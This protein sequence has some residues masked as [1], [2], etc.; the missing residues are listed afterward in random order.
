MPTP[1]VANQ[2]ISVFFSYSHKDE[3]L[4]DELAK[5]L[6]SLKR[7][8]VI[9]TWHDR[10][11]TAGTEW[12]GQL[13][14]HLESAQVIL[15]LV[16][17]DF[18]ASDYCYDIEMKRA[19]ERSDLGEA[20]VIP[21]I[22]RAV[23][24]EDEPFAKLQ[25]LP[26]NIKPI[27][28]WADRDE[29][30][31]DV[32]K[33][34]RKAVNEIRNSLQV[35]VAQKPTS[36]LKSG[37]A[38]IPLQMPPKP[39]NL[40]PRPEH[41]EALKRRLIQE[42][43]TESGT[44]VVSAIYGLGGIGKSVL[45]TVVAHDPDVQ[46][47]FGDGILWIT[48]GQN[49]DIQK[50][51]GAWIQALKDFDYKPTTVEAASNHLR[52]LLYDKRMLLVVDDVWESDHLDPFRVGGKNCSVLVTTREAQIQDA[53]RYE[54]DEMTEAQSIKLLEG[55]MGRAIETEER[56]EV[57]TFAE[58]VGH[59]P[60]ALELSAVQVSEGLTWKEFQDEL[61]A[62]FDL[63]LFDSAEALH[64]SSEEKRRKHSLQACFNL[65]LRRLSTELLHQF[66]GL[67]I[68]PEDVVITPK[69]AST[70]WGIREV[71]AKKVLII[72]KNRAFLTAGPTL[73]DQTQTYRMHDL[74]HD[75]ARWLIAQ[76]QDAEL[77]GLG[78]TVPE[79]QQRFLE[80]Y[81]QQTQAGQWHTLADD[82]YIHA[83]L[84]WH[85]EQAGWGDQIHQ[86]L[87]EVTT[88]GRNGW[89]EACDRL[90]QT[91]IFVTDVGRAWRLAEEMYSE[92]KSRSIALQVRYALIVATLNSLASNIPA[93]LVAALVKKQKWTPAQGLAYAQQAQDSSQRSEIIQ[94]LVANLPPVSLFEKLEMVRGIQDES[95]RATAL[96]ELVP[97]LPGQ[98]LPEAI[99]VAREIQDE[100]DQASVLS[101]LAARELDQLLSKVI[102]VVRGI[103]SEYSQTLILSEL[104]YHLLEL[105][106]LEALEVARGI[107]NESG[108]A[109]VLSELAAHM[110]EK[111]LPEVLK[112]A[113]RLRDKF[114]QSTAL[115]G[116]APYL[117]EQLLLKT[118][119][120]TQGI[121]DEYF[122][123]LVLSSLAPYLPQQLLLK[124]IE[125]AQGIQNKSD[126]VFALS[127][128][129]PYLPQ[130]LL[131]EAIEVAREIQDE[132]SR[133]I[134]VVGLVPHLPQQLLPKALELGSAKFIEVAIYQLN[135]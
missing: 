65:S 6:S 96:G 23:D 80:R 34:I 8:D 54:L 51:L 57:L 13:D 60:L 73:F 53:D 29:A 86:L 79:A 76:P 92:D 4:R 131:S 58:T 129:A 28:S 108:L 119:E 5:H 35:D 113:C 39:K 17:P 107:Q 24:W 90:G 38:G 64:G 127:G 125:V 105:L 46:A 126:R 74:M 66:A 71:K 63:G 134:A 30:F 112:I 16:S 115:S 55:V 50:C 83:H 33:G 7:R 19:L 109:S 21:I 9:G 103:Q 40:V 25:A 3:E 106:S 135:Q 121:Q 1:A 72:L 130:Q 97:H 47:H 87:Q 31:L 70:L 59:L 42:T 88:E 18:L 12:A 41:S 98:L 89:Y 44:L 68:L 11:I 95:C 94:H 82:G 102:E 26:K 49:P 48:L 67:G 77:S 117:T 100:S 111:L 43:E 69:M 27:Q 45:A 36:F 56:T 114:A 75:T 133:A 81:R 32:V 104:A 62:E 14:H 110:S 2:T 128:L 124:A 10:E 101:K 132:H 84:T 22:L 123:A 122:R 52:T 20:R 93:E 37:R 85:M 116:L 120:V 15:L 61:K 118:I 91:A 78:L 99:E